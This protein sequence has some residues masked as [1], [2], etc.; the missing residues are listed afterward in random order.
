MPTLYAFRLPQDTGIVNCIGFQYLK[1]AIFA[2]VLCQHNLSNCMIITDQFFCPY[3]YS[4]KHRSEIAS[5]K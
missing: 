4:V 2:L 1:Q 5:K 3:C